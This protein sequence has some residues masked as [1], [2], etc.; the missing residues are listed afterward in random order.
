MT[1]ST[2]LIRAHVWVSGRVQGVGYRAATYDQAIALKLN[3]WVRNL[4]DGRVEAV[5]E[6]SAE[7]VQEMLRWCHQGSSWAIVDEVAIE[8]E[9]PENLRQFE[10]RQ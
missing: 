4:S 6:G 3:G 7:T 10:V 8:Y 1:D 2:S 5:F 9:P